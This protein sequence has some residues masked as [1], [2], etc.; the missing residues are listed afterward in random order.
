[1]QEFIANFSHLTGTLCT[2]LTRYRAVCAGTGVS[3]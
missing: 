3:E 1:M 2:G